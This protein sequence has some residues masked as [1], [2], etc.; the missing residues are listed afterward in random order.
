M[1]ACIK[2]C[3]ITR[4]HV[5]AQ[6]VALRRNGSTSTALSRLLD[7]AIRTSILPSTRQ[8][9][10]QPVRVSADGVPEFSVAQ[11]DAYTSTADTVREIQV[12]YG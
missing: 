5:V 12:P 3:G 8:V 9:L 2:T 7:D 10:P 4:R 11:L 6:A 1:L